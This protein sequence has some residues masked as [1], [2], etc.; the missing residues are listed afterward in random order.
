LLQGIA[1]I[2]QRWIASYSKRRPRGRELSRWQEIQMIGIPS[3]DSSSCQSNQAHRNL[4][5]KTSERSMLQRPSRVRTQRNAG[6]R[7]P[8]AGEDRPVR[9]ELVRQIRAQISAGGYDSPA[10]IEAAADRLA[11]ALDLLA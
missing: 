3:G 2:P 6:D 10:K 9:T 1:A 8:G 7:L 4:Q 5:S 11:G